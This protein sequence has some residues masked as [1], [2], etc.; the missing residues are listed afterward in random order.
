MWNS[1]FNNNVIKNLNY[2]PGNDGEIFC[3]DSHPW[4]IKG[5]VA[6][7]TANSA[8]FNGDFTKPD[9]ALHTGSW[10]QDWM[11]VIF[12]GKGLGQLRR[13]ISHKA[14]PLYPGRW[15]II[16]DKSWDMSPDSTSKLA[17]GRFHTG[18]VIENNKASD[19]C[20]AILFYNGSIDNVVAFN[21]LKNTLGIA[22]NGWQLAD[23]YPGMSFFN[24]I[25]HNS[26][27]GK[28][29][30][31]DNAW[32]G[33]RG[34]DFRLPLSGVSL[35]GNDFRDNSIDRSECYDHKNDDSR[36]PGGFVMSQVN[37]FSKG[38]AILGSLYEDNT[39][40]NSFYGVSVNDGSVYGAMI[41]NTK[42]KNVNKQVSDNGSKTVVTKE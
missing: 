37:G 20:N 19:C 35:Y 38:K 18:V 29:S 7:S 16:T 8:T 15:I 39:V 26:S 31:F 24:V 32:I 4:L 23:G 36:S 22:V 42:Y 13:V 3:L 17:I 5:R 9:N 10:N 14:D 27:T 6:A 2:V 11:A 1:Y 30:R 25:R 28:S 33:E 34:E 21:E 41:R 12:E 40:L